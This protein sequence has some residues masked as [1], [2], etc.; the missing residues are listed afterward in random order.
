MSYGRM[1]RTADPEHGPDR[2]GD[3]LPD[4][5]A[6]QQARLERTRAAKAALEAEAQSEPPPKTLSRARRR[7]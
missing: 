5:V 7:A 1:A 6:H 4:W 3:E 2:R